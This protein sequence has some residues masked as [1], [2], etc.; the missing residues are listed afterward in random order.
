MAW[1]SLAEFS[2]LYLT[3]AGRTGEFD[4]PDSGMASDDPS[5][6]FAANVALGLSKSRVKWTGGGRLIDRADH[7][8]TNR[9]DRGPS[10][11]LG[12]VPRSK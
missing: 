2:M 1:I 12:A 8:R 11:V 7:I 10:D 4:M 5:S 9:S 3:A 6:G